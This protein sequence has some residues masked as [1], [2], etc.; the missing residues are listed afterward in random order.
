MTALIIRMPVVRK[1]GRKV[2]KGPK[3]SISVIYECGGASTSLTGP[4]GTVEQELDRFTVLLMK[5]RA[6]EVEKQA[7]QEAW[8]E[9]SKNVKRWPEPRRY[10]SEELV[11]M[12][13]EGGEDEEP[14][15]EPE[16]AEA[17]RKFL[18]DVRARRNEILAEGKF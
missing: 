5:R 18:E 11:R 17:R 7:Q 6:R 15:L 4:I 13:R 12:L 16:I 10:R 3:A 2:T 9:R 14:E 1:R 8:I